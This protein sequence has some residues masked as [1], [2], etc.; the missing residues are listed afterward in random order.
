MAMATGPG[1][2]QRRIDAWVAAGNPAA[3]LHLARLN[4]RDG[5]LPNLPDTVQKMYLGYNRFTRLPPLPRDLLRFDCS[6]SDLVELP[7]LPPNLLVLVVDQSRQL[8]QL[9]ELPNTLQHL[10]CM[11]CSLTGLPALPA[12][13][14]YLDCANQ[15]RG[16]GAVVPANGFQELP[17]LPPGLLTLKCQ[18]VGLRSLPPLPPTLVELSCTGNNVGIGI[19]NRLPDLP[20]TLVRLRCAACNLSELSPLPNTLQI[21]ECGTNYIKV[22]PE[23]PHGLRELECENLPLAYF[24]RLP[25]TITRLA[26]NDWRGALHEPF[27]EWVR[28]YTAHYTNPNRITTAEFIRRVNEWHDSLAPRAEGRNLMAL[29]LARPALNVNTPANWYAGP[30]RATVEAMGMPNI[31][32]AIGQ[33]LTARR[34]NVN[35][36]R[37]QL[38]RTKNLR[39]QE[40]QSR[41]V[42]PTS[43]PGASRKRKSRKTR[44]NRKQRKTRR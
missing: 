38:Q 5:E 4:L 37:R 17:P 44:K 31:Q 34:G 24:P 22:L 8:T 3:T 16:F 35:Q 13:L 30:P 27:R 10:S 12:S 36:Q 2:A 29:Q 15:Q 32:S 26:V 33:M 18:Y 42:Y 21:L 25:V 43:G 11:Y 28:L 19:E 9:P 1:E 20:P 7:P 40:L 23:L 6:Y 41:T 39:L 14:T